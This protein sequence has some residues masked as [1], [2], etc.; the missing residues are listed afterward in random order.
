MK[1][2]ECRCLSDVDGKES[3]SRERRRVRGSRLACCYKFIIRLRI[4]W[5]YL[6]IDNC[7]KPRY[8]SLYD[9]KNK[10]FICWRVI[11]SKYDLRVTKFLENF[12]SN[13]HA[14]YILVLKEE[15]NFQECQIP[16]YNGK[17]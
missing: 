12:F 9:I 11:E 15:R 6:K 17:S 8:T 16:L 1:H 14:L 7:D 13:D 2:R 10:I 3:V 5:I 4:Q